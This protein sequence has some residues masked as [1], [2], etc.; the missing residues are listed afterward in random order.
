MAPAFIDGIVDSITNGHSNGSSNGLRKAQY[1]PEGPVSSDLIA[2]VEEF[3]DKGCKALRVKGSEELDYGFRFTRDVFATH[4]TIL[5]DFYTKWKRVLVVMDGPITQLYGD[6]IRA[7]FEHHNIAVTIHTMKGGELNKNMTTMESLVDAFDDFGLIRKEPVLVVGGGIVTDVTGYACASYRRSSNFIRVP[8]TLIGLIDAA[9]SIKV[10][11]NHKK[12]KNRLGA[13][14]APMIT[15]LDFDF[16]KTLPESQVRNGFAEL[17][18]ISSVG[19]IKIWNDMVQYGPDLVKTRF[20]RNPENKELMNIA[21]S[22]CERGIK[23]ML[24]L[25]SPNLHEIKLD[26]VIAFGHTWSP[27]LELSPTVPLRHG[28]A[29]CIDMAYATTL[30]FKRGYITKAERQQF[31]NLAHDVGLSLDHPQFDEELLKLGTA[32]IL[33]T[34]DGK[35]WFAEPKPLG[36]CT[37]INDATEEELAEALREHKHII[38]T[39]FPDL[40]KTGGVGKEAFVDKADLGMDPEEL[41]KQSEAKKAAKGVNAA[42]IEPTVR[43]VGECGC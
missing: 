43:E 6:K 37:F 15:V 42:G 32:A 9:V 38:R 11:I 19:D 1:Q 20:G 3:E 35:Q 18:K 27:V 28:H 10:G 4:Q 39:E 24:E 33:K 23:L 30:A 5:A 41:L 40:I 25:E 34:R 26:R 2:N 12:L 29:I 14:H 8:T 7:Y 16:L 17:I 36:T 21:D 31:H 13:Y 22:I